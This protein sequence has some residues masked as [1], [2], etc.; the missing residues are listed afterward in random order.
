[1]ITKSI[2]DLNV[3]AI[4]N[5]LPDPIIALNESGVIHYSNP[6]FAQMLGYSLSEVIDSN[7][8]DYLEDSSIFSCCMQEIETQ[9]SCGDQETYFRH[10]EGY[11]IPTV[12]NVQVLNDTEGNIESI[13]V[14]IRNLLTIDKINKELK[15]TKNEIKAEAKKLKEVVTKRTQELT[16]TRQQL[17]EILN[18]IGDIVWSLDKESMKFQYISASV[19]RIFGISREAIYAD[20]TFWKEFV[21]PEDY[22]LLKKRIETQGLN[23]EIDCRI[24]TADGSTLWLRNHI[25]YNLEN[26]H[27]NGVTYDITREKA[28]QE[29]IRHLAYHDALTGL[30]NRVQLTSDLRK[31]LNKA[32]KNPSPVSLLFL[33]LDNF[34]FINDSMGHETGDEILVLLSR[35]IQ[36]MLPQENKS[37]RFGG[38]EFIILAPHGDPEKMAEQLMQLF[39][40][41][42]Y[43][44]EHEFFL[45]CSIGIAQYPESADNGSELIKNADTAMYRAK[46]DGKNGYTFYHPS[47]ESEVTD[48]LRMKTLLHNALEKDFFTLYFQPLIDAQTLSLKG[49]EALLRFHHPD[50]GEISPQDFIPVAEATGAILPIGNWVIEQSCAFISEY[51]AKKGV[52]IPVSV[53][54]SAKQFSQKNLDQI[55]SQALN[56]YDIDAQLLHLELTES[57]M[58]EDIDITLSQL[59]KIKELGVKI[60]I[61]DFGTGYSS[62]EYLGRFPVDTIKIDKSFI[63]GMHKEAHKKSIIMAIISLAKAMGLA[64]V[65]EGVEDDKAVQFLQDMGCDTLQGFYFNKALP[66]EL[67]LTSVN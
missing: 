51:R 32:H 63:L 62:F 66:K 58:M 24:I 64:V 9:G 48:F 39:E 18:A 43:V 1:M 25:T 59:E 61:D 53:N 27:V 10:K 30:A 36:K 40:E 3:A 21:H 29:M 60:S 65:A 19:E 44:S 49:A 55:I 5:H 52:P 22:P 42:F 7:I 37:Y 4:L 11:A 13:C 16:Q 17:D 12:K 46:Q 20:G 50:A 6:A 15:H 38:D 47:M 2:H 67:F 56:H 54:I 41:P 31:E 34:K 28:S 26:G 57:V 14:N 23:T 8:L 35:R 33:D 45:S